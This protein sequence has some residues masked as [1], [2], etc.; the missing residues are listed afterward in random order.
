MER[1]C[2]GRHPAAAFWIQAHRQR[3]TPPAVAIAIVFRYIVRSTLWPDNWAASRRRLR[4]RTFQT[5]SK[6][7]N[8]GYGG[9]TSCAA[10]HVHTVSERTSPMNTGTVKFYNDQ[11]GFG[12]IQ[13]ESGEKD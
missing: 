8:P 11:K 5:L 2:G 7:D 6:I 12:F 3:S 1:V 9:E 13:P 4:T 10:S